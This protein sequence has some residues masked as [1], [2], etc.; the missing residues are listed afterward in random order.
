M[1]ASVARAPR[2]PQYKAHGQK[3][4]KLR[5]CLAPNRRP[6]PQQSAA[7]S[8]TPQRRTSCCASST[9]QSVDAWQRARETYESGQVFEGVVR[10][11]NRGGVLVDCWG[12]SGFI[13]NSM[14]SPSGR[15]EEGMTIRALFVEVDELQNRMIL[16]QRQL[17][18]AELLRTIEVGS[19]VQGK[20]SWI[21]GYGAFVDVALA[22]GRTAS[23]LIHKSELSWGVVSV[24]E[25]VVSVGEWVKCKVTDVDPPRGRISLSLR[26]TKP[27]PLK[28][29]FASIIA[30][31]EKGSTDVEWVE[32]TAPLPGL[33]ATVARLQGAEAVGGVSFGRQATTAG[34]VSQELELWLGGEQEPGRYDLVARSGSTIQELVVE[35][36]LSKD[37]LRTLIDSVMRPESA[38]EGEAEA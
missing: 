37:M 6:T 29:S 8:A 9:G 33:E 12:T 32:A 2:N 38:S 28:Q 25:A 3:P 4:S 10:G 11:V 21:E 30:P 26:Q 34:H 16:S 23:G 36:T 31:P 5:G 18:Q 7:V 35:S 24:P 13:P 17:L 22:D 15:P 1:R 27:D 20:V 19:T 14:V